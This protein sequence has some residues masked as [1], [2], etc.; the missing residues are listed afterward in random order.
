M[1]TQE[2]N[3]KEE[4]T[5]SMEDLDEVPYGINPDS[6]S[7]T[8]TKDEEKESQEVFEDV[9]IASILGL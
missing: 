4:E 2:N 9:L 3:Q 7:Y 8:T 6:W 5:S 1:A